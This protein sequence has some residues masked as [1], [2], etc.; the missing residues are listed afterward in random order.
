M[1]SGETIYV[2]QRLAT[3]G[4]SKNFFYQLKLTQTEADSS[5]PWNKGEFRRVFSRV[6]PL[7]SL[8]AWRYPVAQVVLCRNNMNS[9]KLCGI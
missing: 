3:T 9:L 4:K 6:A 8:G 7:V 1:T 2:W 5:G